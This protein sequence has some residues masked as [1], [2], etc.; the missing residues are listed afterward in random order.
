[1]IKW[2]DIDGCGVA[3]DATFLVL[4]AKDGRDNKW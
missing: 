4:Y 1:M 3:V 2:N